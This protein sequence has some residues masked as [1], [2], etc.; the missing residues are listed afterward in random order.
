MVAEPRERGESMI[1]AVLLGIILLF[2]VVIL[3]ARHVNI[4]RQEAQTNI[5]VVAHY[6]NYSYGV[7]LRFPPEWQPTIGATYERYEGA[8]G[9]FAVSAG[10]GAGSTLDEMVNNELDHPLRPYG[11][12]PTVT[13]L[14]I[15][16]QE[17]RLIMPS[18]DQDASMHGQAVIIAKYPKPVTVGSAIYI[19]FIFWADRAHIQ[20]M[21]STITFLNK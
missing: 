8:D 11:A 6:T 12:T 19:Y 9:F 20:D 3:Y 15:D 10:G 2:T 1:W 13:K 21:A 18:S 7:T 16:G 14:Q 4:A 5:P 17:A